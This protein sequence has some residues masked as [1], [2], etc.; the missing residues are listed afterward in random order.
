M[1]VPVAV[2]CAIGSFVF[3][4]A[5][6]PVDAVC[7]AATAPWLPLVMLGPAGQGATGAALATTAREAVHG[8]P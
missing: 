8:R 5:P 3:L 6:I 4:A 7:A 2:A 1:G